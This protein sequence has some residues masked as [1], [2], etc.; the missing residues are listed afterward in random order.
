MGGKVHDRKQLVVDRSPAKQLAVEVGQFPKA[1]PIQLVTA[2]ANALEEYGLEAIEQVTGLDLSGLKQ[3]LDNL[4]ALLGGVDLFG[5]DGFDPVQAVTQFF[6]SIPAAVLSTLGGDWGALLAKLTGGATGGSDPLTALANFLKM[7]LGAPITAGRLPLIPLAHIRNVQPNLLNDPSFDDESTL[8]GFPDWDWD[9]STGRTRPGC[10]YT[11]ADGQTH[12]LRSN[13]VEVGPD[14]VI[15]VEVYAQWVGLA[16]TGAGAVQL[17]IAAYRADDTLI[18]GTPAVVASAGGAG[19]SGGWV[20]LSHD[21]WEVPD[22]AAYVVLELTLTT[23]ATA[24]ALRFDDASLS[25]NGELP[26]S[27]VSGL[28]GQLQQINAKIQSILNK[29]WEAVF[30]D[31][32]G[33]IDRTA[34]ELADALKNIPAANVIGVGAATLVDTVTD[35][36]DNVWRGFTRQPVTSTKSIADVANAATNTSE[37]AD[38][39]LQVGE[40]NNAVLGIRNN[41][42]LSGGVD[43]TAVAM[44][45][46]PQAIGGDLP[47]LTVTSAAVPIAFWTSPNDAKRGSIQFVA[48]VSGSVT[49]F[50][51]DYYSVNKA[52]QDVTLLHTSPDQVPKLAAGWGNIRY[53]MAANLRVD[54]AHGDVLAVGFR[55][56]G[57]GN[58]QL[59]GR[60]DNATWPADAT[61]IPRRPSAT[62]AGVGNTTLGALNWAGDTPWVALGIVEGDVAPP[63]F[64]PRTTQVGAAGAYAYEIPSWANF[65]DRITLSDGGGGAGGNGGVGIAGEG[66]DA[67]I[68]QAETLVRGVD[69]PT[70]GAVLTGTIGNGGNAGARESNGGNGAGVTR[71]AI[72][73]GKAAQLTPGGAGGTGEGTDSD[74]VRGDSPGNFVY[75]GVTYVGGGRANG[76]SGNGE[77]GQP[78]GGGGGGGQGG[79]YTVAWP[80]GKGARGDVWFVARQS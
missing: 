27:Y 61:Q 48:R 80:G 79:F 38:T 12:V 34:D 57:T 78:A 69:F 30:G 35:I 18:G 15:D 14:D 16:V 56:A 60:L 39:G 37:T 9:D 71:N 13:P 47:Y 3:A 44:F 67:G 26:Q 54:T 33:A 70:A 63:Y 64:A 29:A 25:K 72:A 62:R 28:V 22:D 75:R 2:F 6:A 20:K 65:V 76:G 58:V 17:A 31:E 19:S 24:G 68:W 21:D 55:V 46:R 32:E 74:Y 73:G 7:E 10:A 4:K 11:M 50:Y 66:G 51:L 52:T 5:G 1:T 77:A 36:L 59:A 42:P 40:W 23:A 49:A 45:D 53:D 41:T 43:P 8:L